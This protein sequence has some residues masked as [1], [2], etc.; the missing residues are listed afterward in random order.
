MQRA[1]NAGGVICTQAECQWL[2]LDFI[3]NVTRYVRG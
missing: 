1:L 3:G 2:H